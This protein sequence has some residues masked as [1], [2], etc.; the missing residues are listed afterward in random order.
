MKTMQESTQ[1]HKLLVYKDFQDIIVMQEINCICKQ[2]HYFL[3]ES[4][5]TNIESSF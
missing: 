3:S 1:N 5:H 4:V 2:P